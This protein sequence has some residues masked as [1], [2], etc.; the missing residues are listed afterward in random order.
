MSVRTY[1]AIVRVNG[2]K[3]IPVLTFRWEDGDQSS[4]SAPAADQE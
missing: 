2:I 4:Q 3:Y 1:F